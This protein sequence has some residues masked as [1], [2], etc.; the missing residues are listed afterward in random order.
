[1]GRPAKP[2]DLLLMEGKK[3]LTKDEIEERRNAEIKF[4][5]KKIKCPDY[6]K[7]DIIALKKWKELKKLFSDFEFV[8]AGDSEIVARYCVT[9]SEYLDLRKSYQK[10]KEINYDSSALDAAIDAE[11]KNEDGSSEK[12]FTYKV[13]KQ[14]RDM[15]SVNALLTIENAINKKVELLC[16]MEDKMFLNPISKLKNIPKKQEEEKPSAKWGKYGGMSG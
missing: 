4:G 15:I 6:V 9:Y 14:L 10:I 1:M 12:I 3:H 7:D 5:D 2:I 16:K 11:L 13:K 8:S